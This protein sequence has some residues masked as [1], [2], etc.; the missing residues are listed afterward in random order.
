MESADHARCFAAF[1]QIF[2]PTVFVFVHAV[3]Q[4]GIGPPPTALLEHRRFHAL[5]A[6]LARE[7]LPCVLELAHLLRAYVTT[8][9][10]VVG[11]RHSATRGGLRR[12]KKRPRS[13]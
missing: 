6:I 3:H 9:T 4:L 10:S 7:R 5:H 11:H 2:Y 8:D 13:R 12:K 1:I